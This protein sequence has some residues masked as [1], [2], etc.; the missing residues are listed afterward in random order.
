LDASLKPLSLW[1]AILA[2]PA[3]WA[4]DLVVSYALV[5]WTCGS[6]RVVVIRAITFAA[7]T[8]IAAG[9]AIAWR[10]LHCTPDQPADAG[11][12]LPR[13]RFMALLGLA[14]SALFAVAVLGAALP[15]WMLNNACA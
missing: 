15:R 14:S 7:L 1:A 4:L 12:R 8:I 10:A 5:G 2:G 13:A 11:G 6:E 3:A 9:A